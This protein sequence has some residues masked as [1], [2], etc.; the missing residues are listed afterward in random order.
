MPTRK[1]IPVPLEQDVKEKE[2]PVVA[3]PYMMVQG[4]SVAPNSTFF[5]VRDGD[6]FEIIVPIDFDEALYVF[7]SD[8]GQVGVEEVGNHSRLVVHILPI[9][10]PDE[11]FASVLSML[12]RMEKLYLS[13]KANQ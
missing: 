11:V 4:K 9:F 2:T 8:Y 13:E 1:N 3:D 6:G 10:P 12:E 7:L 5:A